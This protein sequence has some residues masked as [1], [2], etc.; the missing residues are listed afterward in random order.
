MIG[1][2]N[3]DKDSKPNGEC[4]SQ[5]EL[6]DMLHT[7]IEAFAK[8]QDTATPSFECLDRRVSNLV[9][10]M[11]M[12]KVRLPPEADGALMSSPTEEDDDYGFVETHQRRRL[13]HNRQGMGANGRHC[14][15]NH[16]P[17][18]DP[19]AKIKFFYST[20]QWFL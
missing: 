16:E 17:Y 13:A 11:D 15:H 20:V 4:V 2:K 1:T 18:N 12:M 8:Y 5:L 3:N 6:K 19:Y 14:Y 9:T 7:M 10:R